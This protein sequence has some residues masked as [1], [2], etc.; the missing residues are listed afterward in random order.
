MS[1]RLF[2]QL[3]RLRGLTRLRFCSGDARSKMRERLFEFCDAYRGFTIF[4]ALRSET[5]LRSRRIAV[6]IAGGEIAQSQKGRKRAVY[7]NDALVQ[8]FR[9]RVKS[10]GFHCGDAAPARNGFSLAAT[11]V[12][13]SRMGVMRSTQRIAISAQ[14]LRLIEFTRERRALLANFRRPLL[15]RVFRPL[16]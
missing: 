13:R 7:R 10:R 15:E 14:S 16:D 3:F 12:D 1:R 11:L 9:F 5:R 2:P 6:Q 8:A 4:F